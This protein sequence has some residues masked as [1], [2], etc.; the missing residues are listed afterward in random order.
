MG[1]T[2]TPEDHNLNEAI[3]ASLQDFKQ[4]DDPS[5]FKE[6]LRQGNRCVL[7]AVAVSRID[8]DKRSS[9]P[10]AL[11][12]EKPS[13]AY[14][15]LALQA[16]YYVPQVRLTVSNLRLPYV[17]DFTAVRD[18]A[19]A[20]WNLIELFTNLDLAQLAALIDST[21][22]SSLEIA[23]LN[24]QHLPE[25]TAGKNSLHVQHKVILTTFIRGCQ[26]YIRPH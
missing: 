10:I 12:P 11:R 6:A 22:L 24:N 17:A 15:A 19:R 21:V 5:P 1:V 16:L 25:A 18:P 8:T 13:L 26:E 7:C 9:R 23:P 14:A 4:D 2:A 20:M 3:Q